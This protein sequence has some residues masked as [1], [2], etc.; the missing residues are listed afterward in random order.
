M[1]AGEGA[2][3]ARPGV[4]FHHHLRRILH[5][6][7][8]IPTVRRVAFYIL[9]GLLLLPPTGRAVAGSDVSW[10]ILAPARA[11]PSFYLASSEAVDRLGNIYVADQ[12]DH[13]IKKLTYTGKLVGSWGSNAPGPLHFTGPTALAVDRAGN[14]YVADAGIVK[15]SPN[16]RLLA[17]W[18]SPSPA[19]LA[20]I[21]ATP[22]G[23]VYVLSAD[24]PAP[25]A[26]Q[27]TSVR[28]DQLSAGGTLVTTFHTAL[29]PLDQVNPVSLTLDSN[30][31][32]YAS[33]A[34][35]VG[36]FRPGECT[37]AY[38]YV[39]ELSPAGLP[40]NTWGGSNAFAGAG[41][42][43]DGHGNVYVGGTGQVEKL[44]SGGAVVARWSSIACGSRQLGVVTGLAFGPTGNLIAADSYGPD[45]PA[46][47]SYGLLQRLSNRGKRLGML[48]HCLSAPRALGIAMGINVAPNGTIFV[49]GSSGVL[50]LSPNGHLLATWTGPR[51]TTY[52]IGMGVNGNIYTADPFTHTV[53]RFTPR[54]GPLARWT[55]SFSSDAGLPAELVQGITV[56]RVG[57]V[58]VT[59]ANRGEVVKFNSEGHEIG[60]FGGPGSDPG[61]FAQPR[62]L[63]IDARGNIYVADM[64]NDRIQKLAPDGAP[65]AQ[66]SN[67][68]QG[69]GRLHQPAGVALDS[70]GN[71]WV[72]D[73]LNNRIVELSPAGKPLA[74]W[75]SS[76]ADPG[77]FNQPAAIAA[78]PKGAVCVADSGND[79]VQ[80]LVGK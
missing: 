45:V 53:S 30:G 37:G 43:A 33:L 62:S 64:G 47:L 10:R 23:Q 65:L 29:L 2:A 13:R 51:Y 27:S 19:R 42:A 4:P 75:G 78:G 12:G 32:I 68:G 49:S 80:I 22:Q 66:W 28:I 16:G 56:D 26:Q 31:N 34:G 59:A 58:Y 14:V 55:V 35:T 21:A 36:C 46:Y 76:G 57:S 7:H 67:L 54:G 17:H 77:Q 6:V 71:I 8:L 39:D 61:L 3:R 40:I 5:A 44:S 1:V 20:G 73:T 69:Y 60:R 48:G 72:A 52:G 70:H 41:L 38:F 24:A 18:A 79:R 15:L 9:A 11:A 74:S 50:E 63:A 25:G